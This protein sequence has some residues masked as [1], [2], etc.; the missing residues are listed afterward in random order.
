MVKGLYVWLHGWFHA[1]RQC[2]GCH[3]I[4]GLHLAWCMHA[5]AAGSWLRFQRACITAD[6][7]CLAWCMHA[8]G[9]GGVLRF[10]S[11]RAIIDGPRHF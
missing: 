11:V 7:P 9:A 5:G 4:D 8:G 2:V 10:R 6:G 3:T 1:M